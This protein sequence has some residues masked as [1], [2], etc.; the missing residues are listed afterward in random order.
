[1]YVSCRNSST[2]AVEEGGYNLVYVHDSSSPSNRT[3]KEVLK[4]TIRKLLP[5]PK[6]MER[7]IC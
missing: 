3:E 5:L 2:W 1:M 7:T 4:A 6:E